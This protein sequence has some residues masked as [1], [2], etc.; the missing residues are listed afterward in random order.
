MIDSK[1][2]IEML[3]MEALNDAAACLKVMA[4]PVRLRIVDI[5]MQGSFPVHAIAE[6]CNIQHHQACEHLR[7]MQSCGFLTSERKAQCV[8]YKIASP[9][10]PLLLNCIREHCGFAEPGE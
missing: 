7:L 10:L 6:M 1:E 9:Q 4:H 5:L 2:K 8:Y 3:P